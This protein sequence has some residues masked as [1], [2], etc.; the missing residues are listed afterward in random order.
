MLSR[1]GY[2]IAD[3]LTTV[4]LLNQ[5]NFP[6]IK[7]VTRFGS[8]IMKQNA[9]TYKT[10]S[11]INN[12]IYTH[13]TE[14]VD[15]RIDVYQDAQKTLEKEKV[16]TIPQKLRGATISPRLKCAVASL[17]SVRSPNESSMCRSSIIDGYDCEIRQQ[18]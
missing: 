6:K 2:N 13:L 12:W 17:M 5:I 14:L 9:A 10:Q 3:L 8:Q 16:A 18:G 1:W 11:G 7:N 4:T 15:L